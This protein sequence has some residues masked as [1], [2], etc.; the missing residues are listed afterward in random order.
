[1]RTRC[2]ENDEVSEANCQMYPHE[3]L[4]KAQFDLF[5]K[6]NMVDFTTGLYG[7]IHGTEDIPEG[8][9]TMAWAT[10]ANFQNLSR[11]ENKSLQ[12]YKISR[13]KL[14]LSSTS[15]RTQTWSLH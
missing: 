10:C 7:Q 3:D 1:M 13:R 2:A 4:L 9:S 5:T 11:N 15:L 14:K 12:L 8:T 6:T